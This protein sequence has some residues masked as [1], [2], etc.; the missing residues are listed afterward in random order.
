M[1]SYGSALNDFKRARGRAALRQVL[2][3]LGGR[4][5][6][7]DLLRFEDVR[8]NG[9]A[10]PQYTQYDPTNACAAPLAPALGMSGAQRMPC[11]HAQ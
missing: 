4:G 11:G 10:A 6:R 5:D 3:R 1:N 7:D 8:R 9:P 2:A